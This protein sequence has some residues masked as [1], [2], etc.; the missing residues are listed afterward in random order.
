MPT[1]TTRVPG[2]ITF[3][4]FDPNKQ[5]ADT[6]AYGLYDGSRFRTF[7]KRPAVLNAVTN[8]HKA[9]LYMQRP[10]GSWQLLT[11]KDPSND[12]CDACNRSVK[13]SYQ[14]PRYY[15]RYGEWAWLRDPY[16][17]IVQPPEL[18]HLC[19]T[20]QQNPQATIRV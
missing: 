13:D 18:V 17:K 15:S 12:V 7:M 11:V 20:C 2:T 6:P 4:D 14:Q 5:F 9:K 3:A 16:G 8:A 1:S 19:K 10:D